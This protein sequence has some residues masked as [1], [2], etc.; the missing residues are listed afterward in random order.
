MLLLLNFLT[1]RQFL[2]SLVQNV[3][4]GFLVIRNGAV[5]ENNTTNNVEL[6]V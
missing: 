2:V 5:T 4:I 3:H 6:L 1:P